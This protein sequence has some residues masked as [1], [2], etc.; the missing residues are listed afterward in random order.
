M[1]SAI[2][3]WVLNFGRGIIIVAV[4]ELSSSLDSYIIIILVAFWTHDTA[5]RHAPQKFELWVAIY[6]D[7]QAYFASVTACA[8]GI[9]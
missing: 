8:V 4:R 2:I 6:H 5:I 1:M 3:G 7:L 9:K